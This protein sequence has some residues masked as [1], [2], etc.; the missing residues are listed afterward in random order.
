MGETVISLRG[1]GD[2]ETEVME[3]GEPVYL[4]YMEAGKRKRFFITREITRIGRQKDQV[5]LP[6]E[7][8]KV[9]KFMHS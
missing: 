2:G 8:N 9:E 3:S 7:N 5:D 6:V 1:G 4:E